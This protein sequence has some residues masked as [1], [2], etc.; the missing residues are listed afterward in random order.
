MK[1][2]WKHMG[3]L[4]LS[5]IAV[6]VLVA[7]ACG[8]DDEETTSGTEPGG[9]STTEA[10]DTDGGGGEEPDGEPIKLMVIGDLTGNEGYTAGAEARA[11]AVNAEG[12]V[13]GRPLEIVSCDLGN[14]PNQAAQCAR[15]AVDDEV[16]AVINHLSG[17]AESINP[18]LEENGICSVGTGA[19]GGGDLSSKVSFPFIG[20]APAAVG[21]IA[22]ILA[23]QE[24]A[25]SINMAYVDIETGAQALQL[26][27]A[28]LASRE[29][30][31]AG[32]TPVP[33]NAADL[34]PQV[35]AATGSGVDGVALALVTEQ[36]VQFLQT[37]HQS[38]VEVP[39]S[40]TGF[41]FGDQ[42]VEELGEAADGVYVTTG[43]MPISADTEGHQMLLSDF[44]AAG[45]DEDIP[46][47]DS[48]INS[49]VSAYVVAE[50][51]SDLDEVTSESLCE[52][53][54]QLEEFD[55]LGLTPPLTT[56]AESQFPGMNRLFNPTVV[57]AQVQDGEIVAVSEDFVNPFA[58]PEG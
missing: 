49:W 34:S 26:G 10:D 42:Q 43:Y 31:L 4:W 50:V 3:R 12:G 14:D 25:K 46:L 44:E 30:K 17:F 39:I 15:Q 24:G 20:G 27:D 13:N 51:A 38:G 45:V 9:A 19:F 47:D 2:R 28:V 48:T 41:T 32:S 33:L 53:M 58:P 40:T 56:T 7:G 18:V 11:E 57:Y 52:A 22:T 55:M 5:L 23:D 29:L 8:G 1:T 35:A 16:A 36:V 6:L 54:G 37:A 21:G